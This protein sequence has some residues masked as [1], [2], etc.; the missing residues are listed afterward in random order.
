MPSYVYAQ[1][2][3]SDIN[4]LRN[5]K[6][7][8]GTTPK[9][10]VAEQNQTYFAYFDG[11][12]GTGPEL[13]DQTA[14]FI[15]Y[16]IDTQGNVANPEPDV[17]PSRP[18]ATALYNLIDNFEPG[19][20]AIVKLIGNDPLLN[21]N[22]NDDALT[23]RYTITHVG[24]IVPILVTETGQNIQDYTTTMSFGSLTTPSPPNIFT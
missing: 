10:A 5:Q 16:I 19:K 20:N 3:P 17:V 18:Q 2:N 24:R 11:V 13:I 1:Q 14:Y 22:P 23:G 4:V 9:Q 7:N 8:Y 21:E 15:K 6:F 12:G